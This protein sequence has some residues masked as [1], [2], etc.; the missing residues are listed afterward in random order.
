MASLG[1][2][3]QLLPQP[4]AVSTNLAAAKW[5]TTDYRHGK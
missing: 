3:C 4:V 2:G 1:I 5:A